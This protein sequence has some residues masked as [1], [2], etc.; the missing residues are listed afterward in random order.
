MIM[1]NALNPSC[2]RCGYDQSGTVET[3]TDRCPV[4]G[5]CPECGTRFEWAVLLDPTRVDLPWLVEHTRGWWGLVRRTPGMVGRLVWPRWFWRPVGIHARIRLWWLACWCVGT[6]LIVHLLTGVGLAFAELQSFGLWYPPNVAVSADDRAEVLFDAFA[7]PW[8]DAE[9]VRWLPAQSLLSGVTSLS[10]SFERVPIL[11][12][13]ILAF[14]VMWVVNLTVMPVTRRAAKLRAAHV[15]RAA[16]I[17]VW[18]ALLSVE[19]ERVA[20]ACWAAWP[21]TAVGS[22]IRIV[23][24]TLQ[25]FAFVWTAVW[26]GSAARTAWSLPQARLTIVLTT[27]AG[28]LAAAALTLW[29]DMNR[30][31]NWLGGIGLWS[32]W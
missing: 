19:L 29:V 2:P 31:L 5:Q 22:V 26:W 14:S 4:Y 12:M 1:M 15:V 25:V 9:V 21:G 6:L 27:L 13:A 3:W 16:I 18:V 23:L 30:V 32:M 10:V 7:K 8:L 28:L 24:P 11:L 17:S 20:E